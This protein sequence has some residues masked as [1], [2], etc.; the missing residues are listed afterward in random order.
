MKYANSL[1]Y[2]NG[3]RS[4]DG[5]ME[6]SDK[7]VKALCAALG[8]VNVGVR[9]I[10]LPRGPA[11]YAASVMLE[12]VIKNS[13]YHVGRITSEFGFDSRN[14]VWVDGKIVPIDDYNMCVAEL[15][16]AVL[17]E[18]NEEYLKEEA[19]FA[20]ALTACRIMGCEYVI[21]QGMSCESYSLDAL[22]APYDLIVVPTVYNSDGSGSEIK[23]ISD[24]IRRGTREVVSGNQK[25][26]VYSR[27]S[28]ACVTSGVR[29][30]F[31]AKTGFAVNEIGSRRLSFAYGDREGYTL[32]S[33]SPILRDCAMLVI[34]SSLAIRR[35]GIKLPWSSISSG[36][37]EAANTGCLEMLSVSPFI[38]IDSSETVEETEMLVKTVKEVVGGIEP[39]GLSVCIPKSAISLL[40]CFDKS[41]VSDVIVC[42]DDEHSLDVGTVIC[43]NEKKAAAELLKLSKSNKNII[44]L[45]GVAFSSAIKAEVLKI[46]NG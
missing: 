7:R 5:D 37:A 29:L 35:D 30:S 45:G 46:L 1:K 11:G 40:S 9:S 16:S 36:L 31:T 28:A 21:L 20:L 44:C 27:I 12:S 33:P 6:V 34:E 13:G 15:K 26:T 19:V 18:Q 25:G 4:A 39:N 38:I 32:K 23:I 17:R 3:F 2:M 10:L 42:A 22:C 43:Q 24:A 14:S 41:I 8:R